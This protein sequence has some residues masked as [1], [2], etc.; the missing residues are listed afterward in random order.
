MGKYR[1]PL[2][3]LGFGALLVGGGIWLWG[4]HSS[5]SGDISEGEIRE[6]ECTYMVAGNVSADGWVLTVYDNGDGRLQVSG[7]EER[8]VPFRMPRKIRDLIG[9]LVRCDVGHLPSGLGRGYEHEETRWIKIRTST[10]EKT[11]VIHATLDESEEHARCVMGVWRSAVR[12][13]EE[14]Q[15]IQES[16]KVSNT[17][18]MPLE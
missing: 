3:L 10:F 15:T 12:I 18:G 16:S 14:A 7:T 11:I 4:R 13:S 6:V 8:S 1:W 2:V 5:D 17:V 9:V